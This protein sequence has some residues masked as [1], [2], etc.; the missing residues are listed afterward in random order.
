VLWSGAVV[1]SACCCGAHGRWPRWY[2]RIRSHSAY[3]AVIPW[4]FGGCPHPQSD[5]FAITSHRPRNLWVGIRLR[6]A[7][8]GCSDACWPTI[9][10][11]PHHDRPDHPRALLASATVTRRAGLGDNRSASQGSTAS[12]LYLARRISEVMQTTRS[13]RR[14]LSPWLAPVIEVRKPVSGADPYARAIAGLGAAPLR[15]GQCSFLPKV[16]PAKA[17][18]REHRAWPRD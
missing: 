7:S 13:R 9:Y 4:T 17:G 5:G 15:F 2:A 6:I 12:G 11:T 1:W 8:D 3:R 16:G 14:H 18:L 10:A